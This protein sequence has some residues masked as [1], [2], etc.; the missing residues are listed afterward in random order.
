MQQ[1]FL[2]CIRTRLNLRAVGLALMIS[3]PAAPPLSDLLWASEASRQPAPVA[4]APSQPV[5]S[6]N[7]VPPITGWLVFCQQ[8]PD[9]C[10]IDPSEPA[11]ITMTPA[12]WRA[13]TTT[14][15]RVNRSITPIDDLRHW[16]VVDRWDYPTDGYGD[17]EDYQLFKR[18]LLVAQGLPRRALHMTVVLDDQGLG[19]AVLMVRTDQGAFIL[20]NKRDAVLL[21]DQ[22]G[23]TYVKRE[24]DTGTA[25]V[26]LGGPSPVTTANR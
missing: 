24:G 25:W 1:P 10:T 16:G 4:A 8:H 3:A 15:L 13:I 9:E 21:T 17:C 26:S 14:N 12:V 19:H 5:T 18:K 20:D 7:Q 11:I 22:T 2:G 6:E 23:Y